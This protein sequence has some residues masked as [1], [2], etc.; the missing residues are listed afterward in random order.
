MKSGK[1]GGG[2]SYGVRFWILL[3]WFDTNLIL[4]ITAELLAA[5]IT[6]LTHTSVIY[7]TRPAVLY[8]QHRD[9]LAQP[10][11]PLLPQQTPKHNLPGYNCH[12]FW[13]S[14]HDP[15][16]WMGKVMGNWTAWTRSEQSLCIRNGPWNNCALLI[17]PHTG[18]RSSLDLSGAVQTF[19]VHHYGTEISQAEQHTH[20][21]TSFQQWKR[22]SSQWNAWSKHHSSFTVIIS[23]Q[24]R[25]QVDIF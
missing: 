8:L 1:Q 23:L 21:H 22:K 5:A 2:K 11:R 25:S 15:L 20:K 7:R 10:W 4:L 18:D 16:P 24:H 14:G 6:P 9:F 3:R 17:K 19:Q 13:L 12:N